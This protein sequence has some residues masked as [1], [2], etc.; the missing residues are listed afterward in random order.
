MLGSEVGAQSGLEEHRQ[1]APGSP[2]QGFVRVH[3]CVGEGSVTSRELDFLN[4]PGAPWSS[5]KQPLQ[6]VTLYCTLDL[7][8]AWIDWTEC[9]TTA[10]EPPE[11]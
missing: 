4:Q 5:L 10:K 8:L 1:G 9:G 6:M 3:H 2:A 7:L 11:R